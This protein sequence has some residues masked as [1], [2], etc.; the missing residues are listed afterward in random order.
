MSRNDLR[1]QY[2]VANKE[3]VTTD[4]IEALLLQ[5]FANSF[6]DNQDDEKTATLI[7]QLSGC[8]CSLKLAE[9]YDE[10]DSSAEIA[11]EA[12]I[13]QGT[14]AEECYRNKVIKLYRANG[15]DQLYAEEAASWPSSLAMD[16]EYMEETLHK[17][18]E[19]EVGHDLLV[20]DY[21]RAAVANNYFKSEP[22][23][24]SEGN[25]G[26]NTK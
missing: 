7:A 25:D 11:V 23:T 10:D 20:G 16:A 22:A 2:L 14:A 4:M 9:V 26:G 24:A 1:L 18:A 6:C 8:L 19:I 17:F 15:A 21:I 12:K 5:A 3:P 13:L